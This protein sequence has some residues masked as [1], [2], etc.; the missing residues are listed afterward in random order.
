MSP[1]N[2]AP[3]AN[4]MSPA[5]MGNARSPMM[6][7]ASPAYYNQ[8][9]PADGHTDF[10]PQGTNI[11]NAAALPYGQEDLGVQPEAGFLIPLD[12]EVEASLSANL[13][14]NINLG[15]GQGQAN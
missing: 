13:N 12:R 11:N 10:Q 2:L 4:G 8:Y 15:N 9:S 6:E 14:Q 1:N 5:M 3:A 7:P